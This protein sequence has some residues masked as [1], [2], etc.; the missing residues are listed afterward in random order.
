MSVVSEMMLGPGEGVGDKRKVSGSSEM[1][2]EEIGGRDGDCSRWFCINCAP[3]AGTGVLRSDCVN[4]TLVSFRELDVVGWGQTML[5][6]VTTSRSIHRR[7]ARFPL[8]SHTRLQ[9]PILI[10]R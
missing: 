2:S 8:L 9:Q 5:V 10:L 7:L 1:C 6:V 4:A 3:G